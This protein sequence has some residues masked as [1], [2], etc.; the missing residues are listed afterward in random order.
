MMFTLW[1]NEVHPER[2][3]ATIE[4]PTQVMFFCFWTQ[5]SIAALLTFIM[6]HMHVFPLIEP[7]ESLDYLWR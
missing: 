7:L 5:V 3:Y 1:H 4:S 2:V 6:R